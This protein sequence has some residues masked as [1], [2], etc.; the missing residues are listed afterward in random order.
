MP[1]P[2][3]AATTLSIGMLAPISERKAWIAHE[4]IV[5]ALVLDNAGQDDSPV[6]I[7]LRETGELNEVLVLFLNT[8]IILSCASHFFSILATLDFDN[9]TNKLV[10]WDEKSGLVKASV[11]ESL[12]F[13]AIE[14]SSDEI[15]ISS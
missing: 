14:E 4:N 5:V 12:E 10:D 6:A 1:L 7:M 8:L 9:D 15:L 13:E 11:D 3:H 2:G